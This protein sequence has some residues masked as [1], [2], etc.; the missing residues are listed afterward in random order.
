MKNYSIILILVASI[1]LGSCKKQPV[2]PTSSTM[3]QKLFTQEGKEYIIRTTNNRITSAVFPVPGGFFKQVYFNNPAAPP[4]NPLNPNFAALY[5]SS[6]GKPIIPISYSLS[7]TEETT[8]ANVVDIS[9]VYYVARI[10]LSS[11]VMPAYLLSLG[12]LYPYAERVY[13]TDNNSNNFIVRYNQ[14]V[15]S[16]N[17]F[18][19]TADNIN[20]KFSNSLANAMNSIGLVNEIPVIPPG[21]YTITVSVTYFELQ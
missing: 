16:N 2:Q 10:T 3:Q 20:V 5:V 7:V 8:L 21:T 11:Q 19:S 9:N 13:Y 4:T 14:A 18:L 6:G 15:F 12:K 17:D 1:S